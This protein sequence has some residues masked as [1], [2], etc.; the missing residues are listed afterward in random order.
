M[1]DP[2]GDQWYAG[3]LPVLFEVIASH[4]SLISPVVF[5]T[6][7]SSP[8]SSTPFPVLTQGLVS[9]RRRRTDFAVRDSI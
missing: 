5:T 9:T 7:R 6:T 4:H 2:R 8:L 1:P 3:L